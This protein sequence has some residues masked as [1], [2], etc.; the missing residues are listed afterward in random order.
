MHTPKLKEK[1]KTITWRRF[2]AYKEFDFNDLSEHNINNFYATFKIPFATGREQYEYYKEIHLNDSERKTREY[3]KKIQN[4][5]ARRIIILE[6]E[7]LKAAFLKAFE[8]NE[9]TPYIEDETNEEN[10][11]VV[12]RY[13]LKDLPNFL[14][15]KN[16]Y[17]GKPKV[18]VKGNIIKPLEYP[19]VPSFKKG[20]LIVGGYGCGKTAMMRAFKKVFQNSNYGFKYITA[21]AL[22]NEYEYCDNAADKKLFHKQINFG[23]ACIDDLFTERPAN[24]YGK[25]KIPKE[26]LEERYFNKALTYITCN[27]NPNYKNNLDEALKQFIGYDQKVYDRVFEM[28][29]IIEFKNKSFRK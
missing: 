1:P 6:Y 4:K 24:N 8:A 25:V 20:L 21:N 22:V 7:W 27:Y 12:L 3:F 23:T 29:N 16:I 2:K 15:C 18:D 26:V 19:L 13:F 28:F 10:L 14:A 11:D 17:L 5:P 9:G